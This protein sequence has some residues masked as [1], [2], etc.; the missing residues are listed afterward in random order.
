MIHIKDLP[1]R[2]IPAA[3]AENVL[4]AKN[5]FLSFGGAK[6]KFAKCIEEGRAEL[7]EVAVVTQFWVDDDDT[8]V[9]YGAVLTAEGRE[10]CAEGVMCVGGDGF[11]SMADAPFEREDVCDRL[12]DDAAMRQSAESVPGVVAHYFLGKDEYYKLIRPEWAKDLKLFAPH[13]DDRYGHESL[14]SLG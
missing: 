1:F 4:K 11:Y 8:D 2:T 13:V 12:A 14:V 3:E 10:L 5:G 7:C 9:P 6:K